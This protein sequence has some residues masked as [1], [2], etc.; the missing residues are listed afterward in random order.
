MYVGEDRNKVSNIVGAQLS[1]FRSLY[2]PL[3]DTMNDYIMIGES[4]VT[5]I[6]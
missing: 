1:E 4:I 5:N 6:Q 3:I 2:R